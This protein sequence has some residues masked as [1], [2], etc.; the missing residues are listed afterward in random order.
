MAQVNNLGV[1][2]NAS[3]AGIIYGN[4]SG[5]TNLNASN[6]SS[7]ILS[8]SYGGTGK[9]NLTDASN[10][11][12]NALSTGSSTPKD[13]DYFISQYV[14]GGTT[15]TTY[16][17]RKISALWAY[18]QGKTDTI[19]LKL[20]GG[21][22]TGAT[23]FSGAAAFSGG[24]TFSSK[25]FNYSGIEEATANAN[26]NIWF[27]DSG[28]IG[29]P[30]YNNNLKYNPYTDVL[31]V[32]SITG[33]AATATTAT[34]L[35]SK[36]SLAGSGNAITVTA[37]GQTSDAFTVPYATKATQDGDG[38][39]ITSSYLPL[40]GGTMT[41]TISAQT[42]APK[43]DSSYSLGLS[44]A[45][46]QY[47]YID[48][49]YVSNDL[50]YTASTSATNGTTISGSGWI[51]LT[52]ADTSTTPHIDFKLNKS[53]LDYQIRIDS[54]SPGR[55]RIVRSSSVKSTAAAP[56][57][58]ANITYNNR[59]IDPVF[60][61][62]GNIYT[63]GNSETSGY[64]L[65]NVN[66]AGGG[67]YLY[68]QNSS[69]G[70]LYISTIGT[71]TA[72]GVTLLLLGNGTAAGA[73]KNAT[74]KIRLYGNTTYY[75]E[76]APY[77]NT[78]YNID[79][80]PTA[81]RSKYLPNA[82]GFLLTVNT[83]P[84]DTS[85]IGT[86]DTG[87]YPWT[88]ANWNHYTA[89][90][91]YYI[92]MVSRTGV[93]Y[94]TDVL[95]AQVRLYANTTQGYADLY[96]G[97][98]R[99]AGEDTANARGRIYMYHTNAAYAIYYP[100]AWNSGY[101]QQSADADENHKYLDTYTFLGNRTTTA[102]Q[103]ANTIVALGNAY[104]YTSTSSHSEGILQ[105]YGD[106]AYYHRIRSG[107]ALKNGILSTDTDTIAQASADSGNRTHYLPNANGYLLTINTKA[108]ITQDDTKWT[109]ANWDKSAAQY[110][111]TSNSYGYGDTSD[112]ACLKRRVYASG[113]ST[114]YSQLI[115]GNDIASGNAANAHGTLSLYSDSSYY[116]N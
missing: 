33:N 28:T 100:N 36:P 23:T 29:K 19:Y 49:L 12:I 77:V 95:H 52:T 104:A 82:S 90:Q 7:G 91:G 16:H 110:L 71:E 46:W 116:T 4:G 37:G 60:Y 87:V 101:T 72:E 2:G 93:G 51:D 35:A 39:T 55:V 97:N 111:V 88:A 73:A 66:A 27:S 32:G 41:G 107:G 61:T 86:A 103:L 25:S 99:K 43:T 62:V 20:A 112:I 96:L 9:N 30:C 57:M 78:T 63:A 69:Y 84:A 114:G 94:T 113:S 44:S 106:L 108:A 11:L 8:P 47:G 38:N 50:G 21:T 13:D 6:I 40:A 14:D 75:N 70:R 5:I 45:H 3:V 115:L 81:N 65:N 15:T 1:L 54:D 89:A 22:V 67:Y 92:P 42:I 34:N 105:L 79:T 109:K 31:T 17:R 10:A 58:S 102:N 53:A 24:V 26:R 18:I 68:G 56:N 76:I 80:N 83:T 74:G 64:F 48:T 98:E 85:T 59:E